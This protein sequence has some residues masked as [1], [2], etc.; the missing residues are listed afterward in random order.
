MPLLEFTF[1]AVLQQF[2]ILVAVA[3][4]VLVVIQQVGLMQLI[5]A[6]LVQAVLA[7]LTLQQMAL[8]VVTQFMEWLL[9]VVA[10]GEEVTI[11]LL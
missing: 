8:M 9:Q 4:A 1:Q 5:L 7:L 11:T 2:K 3:V 6:P 10:Q